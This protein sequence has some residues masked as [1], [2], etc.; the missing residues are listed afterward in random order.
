MKEK[1]WTP[2]GKQRT[3]GRR[4]EGGGGAGVSRG[5]KE[6]GGDTRGFEGS[7]E[8]SGDRTCKGGALVLNS[9]KK[10]PS[11]PNLKRESI[12]NAQKGFCKLV[13]R[14][15][16]ITCSKNDSVKKQKPKGSLKK[17]VWGN[18]SVENCV[19]GRNKRTQMRVLGSKSGNK[20]RYLNGLKN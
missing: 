15:G 1:D 14:R 7:P 3:A 9:R 13:R 16:A 4:G 11:P 10:Q 2:G 18:R 17:F 6:G 20:E 12:S 19:H 5:D 8:R